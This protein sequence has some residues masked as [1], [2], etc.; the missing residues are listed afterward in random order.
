LRKKLKNNSNIAENSFLK[1][2]TRSVELKTLV[3]ETISIY[4]IS[5]KTKITS[6]GLRYELKNTALPFGVR[7]STSNIAIKNLVKL[8]IK[9][10]VV[11]VIRD[12]KTMIDNDLF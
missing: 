11:F 3:G 9:N 8:K 1:A 4:G 2:Y 12:I 5:P 7:E 6:N 10:G